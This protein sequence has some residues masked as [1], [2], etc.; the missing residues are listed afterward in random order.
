MPGISVFSYFLC[1]I[2][3][4]PNLQETLNHPLVVILLDFFFSILRIGN[5]SNCYYG[6]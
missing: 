4:M 1:I 5:T 2:G 6:L 3:I